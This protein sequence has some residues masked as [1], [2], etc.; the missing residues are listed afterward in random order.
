[1]VPHKQYLDAAYPRSCGFSF[2]S[3]PAA[4]NSTLRRIQC[5]QQSFYSTP[6]SASKEKEYQSVFLIL[7]IV[8]P[9]ST[10]ITEIFSTSCAN[11]IKASCDR[12]KNCRRLEQKMCTGGEKHLSIFLLLL[13]LLRGGYYLPRENSLQ[14]C[15]ITGSED[16]LFA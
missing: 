2:L 14:H 15:E 11:K 4:R 8:I 10:G 16:C 13:H 9:Q 3:R 1:M 12:P 7:K 6:F 5:S